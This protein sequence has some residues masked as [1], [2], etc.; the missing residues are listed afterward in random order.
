MIIMG[1]ICIVLAAEIFFMIRQFMT[2]W[3]IL[4][5]STYPCRTRGSVTECKKIKDDEVPLFRYTVRF[6][7]DEQPYQFRFE[8]QAPDNPIAVGKRI[9]V[10]YPE[11]KP[12]AAYAALETDR[13]Q[14]QYGLTLAHI[15]LLG[16]TAFGS[17]LVSE[18][19]PKSLRMPAARGILT[20]WIAAW[21][22]FAAFLIWHRIYMRTQSASTEGVVLRSVY[23]SYRSSVSYRQT[24]RYTVGSE[25]YIFTQTQTGWFSKSHRQGER[26]PIRYLKKAPFAAECA[27]H[28]ELLPWYGVFWALFFPALMLFWY[29]TGA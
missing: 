4:R 8:R 11:G 13:F 25:T 9:V 23:H 16:L 24:I 6:L 20:I 15:A 5:R 2:L 28:T 21:L 14:K 3:E 12:A 29:L 7:A 27:D 26:I 18:F 10:Y 22:L 19:L 1:I 17:V